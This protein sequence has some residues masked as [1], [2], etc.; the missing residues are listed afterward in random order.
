LS[1]TI[2]QLRAQGSIVIVVTHRTN[3]LSEVNK[4][5][6]VQDGRQVFFGDKQ[7]VLRKL[8]EQHQ[9]AVADKGGL[10]V[11]EPAR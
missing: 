2:K 11:V 6:Q 7:D 5:M 4:L 10:R 3:V 8:R 1:A 9:K